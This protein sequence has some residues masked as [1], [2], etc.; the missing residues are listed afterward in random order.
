MKSMVVTDYDGT[1]FVDDKSL[2][3]NI[4]AVERFRNN[5]GLFII[6]TGNNY[7]HFLKVLKKKIKYDYLILDQGSIISNAKN[8][9]I[10]SCFIDPKIAEE[11][12]QILTNFNTK[13]SISIFGAKRIIKGLDAD[14]ITKLSIR[15]DNLDIAKKIVQMLNA[16]YMNWINAYV[17]IFDDINIIEVIS[18]ETDKAKAIATIAQMEG[19]PNDSVYTIGNGY[20]DISMIQAFNGYCMRSS[21]KELLEICSNQ[22]DGVYELIDYVISCNR[23]ESR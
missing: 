15:I 17:M 12:Y 10:Y 6:A 11:I 14:N 22:V 13:D 8:E 21:V 7:E 16:K 20:N 18:N 1:F 3:E 4:K 23:L 5:N 2:K 19:I 9:I